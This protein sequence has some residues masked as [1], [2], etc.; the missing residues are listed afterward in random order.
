[1]PLTRIWGKG[2]LT[3]P[4]ALRRELGLKEETAVAVVKVGDSLLIV[5]KTMESDRVAARFE[6]RMKAGNITF[7]DLLKE[8]KKARKGYSRE[9]HAD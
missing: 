5:P 1:M 9:Q 4:V 8:L 3:I 6:K 2:Q 7:Q